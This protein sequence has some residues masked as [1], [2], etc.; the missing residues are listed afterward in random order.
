[1]PRVWPGRGWAYLDVQRCGARDVGPTHPELLSVPH[2]LREKTRLRERRGPF[3]GA[4]KPDA[5]WDEALGDLRKCPKPRS[6]DK[7]VIVTFHGSLDWV[8]LILERAVLWL[9]D[10]H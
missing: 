9:H 2:E 10:C 4:D 3:L 7:S 1:M 5:Q 8:V 6:R